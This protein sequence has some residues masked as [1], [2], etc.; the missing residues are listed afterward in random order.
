MKSRLLPSA[1]ALSSAILLAACGA[2]AA[3]ASSAPP[4]A[5]SSPA[6]STPASAAAKPSA[7]APASGPA[8]VAAKP[9]GSAAASGSPA[10]SGASSPLASGTPLSKIGG[11]VSVVAS[12]GGDEQNSFLAM[13]K[14]FEDQTGVQVQY[15]GTR[16]L[17]TVLSTRVQAGN[18]PEIAA[19]PGPGQ[20]AQFAQAGKLTDLSGILDVNQMKSQYAPDWLTL[21]TVNGKLVGVFM[22]ADLKSTIWYDPKS[23]SQVNSGDPPKTWNDLMTLSNSIAGSGKTPWCIGLESAATSGWPGTDWISDILMRSAGPDV[24]RQWYGGQLAWTSPEVKNAWQMWGQIAGN[25]KMVYGGAQSMLSTNFANAGTPLFGN[26]PGCYM[27]RQGDFITGNYTS[28]NPNLK[29]VTDFN[30]FSFPS[31]NSQYSGVSQVSGDIVGM[32]KDT[33]QA[34]ALIQYLTTPQAQDVWVKRGG[35]LS[36]NKQVPNADYPDQLSRQL[37]QS[38][39]SAQ[40]PLFS[41]GDMMPSAMQTAFYKGVLSFVQN[42]NQLDS[43]LNGLEQTRQTAYKGGGSASASA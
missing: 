30:Y 18:P 8:S 26:P 31:I 15:T 37:A 1:A 29:P 38:L 16:D 19:L 32:F 24:Y 40:T 7:S 39:V 2:G 9:S 20:M 13:V 12:W 35:A 17:N 10:G 34:R 21:G 6:A 28:N 43:I 23:F 41:A 33:P 3:P 27:E 42:P 11:S 22:K 5:A 25:S 4:P 14:P 36:P